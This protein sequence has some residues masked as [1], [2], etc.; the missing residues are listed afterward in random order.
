[1]DNILKERKPADT[2]QIPYGLM[3]VLRALQKNIEEIKIPESIDVKNIDYIKLYLRTEL[4][5]L[6]KSFAESIKDLPAPI[7]KPTFTPEIKSIYPCEMKVADIGTLIDVVK[8]LQK[9]I[10]DIEFKPEIKVDA[11]KL[12]DI[13]LPRQE[14]PIIN[15][16][17]PQVNVEQTIDL[18][19][20]LNALD[21]LKYL[22]NKPTKPLSVRLADGKKFIEALTNIVE[23]QGKF[24]SQYVPGNPSMTDSEFRKEFR[25]STRGSGIVS[26][27]KA[28]SSAGTAERLVDAST[29]CFCV[30]IGADTGNTGYVVVG[31]SDVVAAEDSQKGC[32]LFAGNPMTRIYIDDVY[33][34]YADSTVNGD[35]VIFNYYTY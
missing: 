3:Q 12:P 13:K 25:K 29:P 31:G 26:G 14:K 28:V 24:I 1:M 23:K 27:A 7:Y 33:K 9:T 20:L 4:S 35:R 8:E 15:V 32:M 30:D 2:P 22:S 19:E 5:K 17:P 11:P 16:S 6:A 18:S 34:L 10:N 21:P